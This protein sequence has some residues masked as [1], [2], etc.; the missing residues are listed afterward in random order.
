MKQ[1]IVNKLKDFFK[2]Q[3]IEKAWVFGSYSRGEETHES[4]IERK[5]L[6]KDIDL[7]EEGQLKDFA[8]DSAERD[9]ILIYERKA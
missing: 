9:K 4:D 1:V 8:K 3:P 6:H 2:L 7:V 5:V